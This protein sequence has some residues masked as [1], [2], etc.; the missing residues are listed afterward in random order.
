[1]K[2]LRNILTFAA[3][4]LFAVSCVEEADTYVKGEAD[5][6]GCYGVYFPAQ[7][8]AGAHTYDP[9]MPTEITFTLART[10]SKGE[11]TVPVVPTASHDGIFEIPAVTFADGQAETQFTVTFPNSENGIKY[12]LSLAI[13]DPQYAS[14]YNDGATNLDFSVLRVEWLDFLNPVTNEPAVVTFYEGWWGEVH[15]ATLKYYEVNGV[16]TCVATCNETDDAGNPIGIWGD[17][18]GV[19]FNFTWYTNLVN[20]NGYQVL[21][22]QRQ[23]LG[24]DYS[25]WES[26]PESE[27]SAPIYFYDWF[28][29]LTT[30]GGY[31]GA[32]ADWAGFL[33]KNPGA[34][35]QSYYDGNGG[36]CFNLRYFVPAAGGG[37]TPDEFDVLAI[38]EGFTRV[39]YSLA[40][41]TGLTADGAV[42]VTFELGPDVAKVKYAAYEG[43]LNVAQL[44]AKVAAISDGTETAVS[45]VSESSTV[46]ISMDATGKY[47]LVAVAFD[48]EGNVQ[49]SASTVFTFV[50]ADSPVPVIVSAGLGS[51]D[52]YVPSGASTETSLEFWVYGQDL[53]EAK[54]GVF[55]YADLVSDMEGCQ[56]KLLASDSISADA[57]AL[58]NG[59]GYVDVVSGL[60]PGT[61]HYLLVWASNGYETTIVMSNGFYTSGDPLPVYKN[62]SSADFNEE[63]LPS[64]SE[65]YF[66]TYN[67]YAV[68]YFGDSPLRGYLGQV[69]VSDSEIPDAEADDYGL[70]AEY[71]NVKGIFGPTA[72]KYGFDDTMVME[73]YGGVLYQLSTY[74]DAIADGAY[75]P[76]VMYLTA[77]GGLYGANNNY[78]MFGGF[79]DEGYIAFVDATGNYGFNGWLLRAFSD[80]EYTTAV[81]NFACYQ[82]VLLVDPAVDDNGLA[83]AQGTSSVSKA[84]LDMIN[85][86]FNEKGNCVETERGR[87][88]SIIDSVK[89]VRMFDSFMGIKGER[90]VSSVAFKAVEVP[91]TKSFNTRSSQ[92]DNAS[93]VVNY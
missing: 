8:A 54:V 10:N 53:V 69:T 29:Y 80:A 33:A 86:M 28:Y 81:G 92:I 45:E 64:A 71:V 12:S 78:T 91:Y 15:T 6:E 30:D 48:A 18:A 39:D 75:Y 79:V 85:A 16:R 51:A 68:D 22:V 66:G 58:A 23:Y 9:S 31:A 34:Y 1:M 43:E 60:V 37:W 17:N 24:F 35:A 50:A 2:S 13:T 82:D 44:E 41:S 84:Q 19:T 87:I 25:D 40:L 67:Y 77:A 88:H 52:K 20:E 65:G 70:V 89:G 76:A 21:D 42:P 11:I 57:V 73:Y 32:W 59:E 46:A 3:L 63:L 74:Y 83:P 7:E 56:E 4:S 5:V 62:Y 26:K 38:A 90:E 36:F 61:E 14:K 47:T 72:E 55:T 27:A 93:E 49:N